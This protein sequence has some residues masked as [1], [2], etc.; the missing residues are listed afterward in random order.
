MLAT[1]GFGQLVKPYIPVREQML[2]ETVGEEGFGGG[3]L[4][5]LRL[6]LIV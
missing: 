2:F 6:A 3:V 4:V 1:E 5:K